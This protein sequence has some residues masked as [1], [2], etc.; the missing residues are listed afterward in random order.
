MGWLEQVISLSQKYVI[1]SFGSWRSAGVTKWQSFR[2]FIFGILFPFS[3][4]S[5]NHCNR[6]FL[7]TREVFCFTEYA[8]KF[9]DFNPDTIWKKMISHQYTGYW[10]WNKLFFF[11]RTITKLYFDRQDHRKVL[12]FFCRREMRCYAYDE[13]HFCPPE[14]KL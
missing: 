11:K 1:N 5:V 13:L 7:F 9:P 8:R 2:S 14:G 6:E 3:R 4:W 10:C 12:L